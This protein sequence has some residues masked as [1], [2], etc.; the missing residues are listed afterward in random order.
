MTRK[1]LLSQALSLS[2]AERLELAADLLATV[3]PP[4]VLS[5]SDAGFREEIARR[6]DEARGDTSDGSTWEE[7]RKSIEG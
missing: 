1:Q 3:S 2:E 5:D 7:V 6:A 4:G